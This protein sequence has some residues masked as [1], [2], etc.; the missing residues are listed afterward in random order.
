MRLNIIKKALDFSL[1][2]FAIRFAA[3]GFYSGLFCVTIY[4]AV[5][6]GAVCAYVDTWHVE[7]VFA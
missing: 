7:A 2:D 6:A 4:A 1:V 5:G 3:H